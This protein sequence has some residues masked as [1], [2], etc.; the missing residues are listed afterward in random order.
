MPKWRVR[1]HAGAVSGGHQ[2]E[3]E[4]KVERRQHRG[5]ACWHAAKPESDV[6]ATHP[7]LHAY[8]AAAERRQAFICGA[9]AVGA[10]VIACGMN[11][12]RVQ[13]SVGM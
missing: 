7:V 10:D 5:V 11:T 4:E 6:A 13:N 8:S 1:R 3:G 12:R 9:E 2:V